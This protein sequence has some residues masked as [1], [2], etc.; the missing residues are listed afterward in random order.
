VSNQAKVGI[1]TT[2][3]VAIFILGFYFLKGKNLW[4]RKDYYYA[5]YDRIDGLYKSNLVLINGFPVGRVED[6]DMDPENYHIV[7][8]IET[9]K[10]VKIPA[11]SVA[12][13]ISTDLLGQKVL[14]VNLGDAGEYLENGDTLITGFERGLSEQ[15]TPI[16]DKVN[17][18]LPK[19][20]STLAGL[21]LLFNTNNPTGVISAVAK[22]NA[23]I[24]DIRLTV[25]SVNGLVA[26]NQKSIDA[27]MKNIESISANFEKNNDNLTNILSNVSSISDSL[28][29]ANLK[30]TMVELS[31]TV[32]QLKMLLDDVNKGNGSLGKLVKQD[33]LYNHIDSAVGSLDFLLK[34]VKNRPY[35][36]V[37]VTVFGN[38]KREE[39]IEKKYNE[40]G[41]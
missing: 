22:L 18:M 35:R 9:K 11:N 32:T 7:I 20:D 13:L 28:Q 4:E 33:E 19:L 37:N 30:Q 14:R 2:A 34:D 8:K 29:Q 40:S 15:F 6:M 1:L 31:A 5:V 10:G 38:K 23:T 25:G 41:K 27:T 21:Q 36:Y 12:E 39:R 24:D 17:N 3:T 16:A 26:S